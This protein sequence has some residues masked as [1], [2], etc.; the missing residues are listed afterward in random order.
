ME[1][2]SARWICIRDELID[3]ITHLRADIPWPP[4]IRR[5]GTLALNA[6]SMADAILAGLTPATAAAEVPGG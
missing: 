6:E 2:E 1:P 4:P 5:D 3:A